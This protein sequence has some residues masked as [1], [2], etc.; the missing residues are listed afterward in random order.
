L[1]AAVIIVGGGITGIATAF[2][3]PKRG[4]DVIII[5]ADQLLQGTT[6]PT[7][8]KITSQHD[9]Y[10]HEL[11]Q[12]IG[13]PK[14]RLYVEANEKAKELIQARVQKYDSDCQ[15]EVKDAYLYTKEE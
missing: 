1:P 8:A 12:Q 3:L 4:L 13:M 10:Y 14:A 6:G 5:D 7:T 11:I 15:L 2:A 9:V